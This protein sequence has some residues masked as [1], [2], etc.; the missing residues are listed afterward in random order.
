MSTETAAIGTLAVTFI[1]VVLIDRGI[2]NALESI[3]FAVESVAEFTVKALLNSAAALRRRHR[4]IELAH[5]Q[6]LASRSR[7]ERS[8]PAVSSRSTSAA[9]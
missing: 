9:D 7:F 8:Q 2:P 3:A 4:T 5:Q 6:R 1:L